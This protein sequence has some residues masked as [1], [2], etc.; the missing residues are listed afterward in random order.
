MAIGFKRFAEYF[1]AHR[2][3]QRD[4]HERD[5]A[6]QRWIFCAIVAAFWAWGYWHGDWV[7]PERVAFPVF[8]AATAVV[9]FV[10]RRYLGSHPGSGVGLQYYFLL[11]DAPLSVG[12]LVQ[13]PQTFTFLNPFLLVVVVRCGIRYGVRTMLLVWSITVCAALAL[14]PTSVYWRSELVLTL[15]FLL[16]LALVPVFF[17]SLVRKIHAVRAI[18]EE[19]ARFVAVHEAVVARS[20]FLA[21]VSHELRSPLQ[22]IVSALDVL[23]MRHGHS[24]GGNDELIARM[25]RSSLLLNTQL[26]DLL[27]LANGEAGRLEMHPS[28]FEACA[29]LEGVAA[30]AREL[31]L[32][33]GLDLVID[34]P[35]EAVFVIADGA[36]IDQVLTNLAI[37][38]I[39][40]TDVG[41]VRL[42][43]HAYDASS[44]RLR[45]A[46]ADTGPGIPEAVLPTLFA[47]DKIMTGAE[48][49]GEGSGIGLAIVRTLV[50]HL[51]GTISVTS[52]PGKGTAFK[53]EI[54]AEAVL[55]V[56]APSHAASELTGRVLI[57]DDRDDV[58]DALADVVDELG[59]ECDRASSAAI[60]ANLLATRPYDV[61]LLDIEMPVKGGAELAIETRRGTGPNRAT[62]FIGMSAAGVSDD[63]ARHFDACFT[64]PID[65]AALHQAL[66]GIAHGGARPSQPGLWLDSE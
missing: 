3:P 63:I 64:K 23:E 38:S 21:K 13:D 48:R 16:M 28:P 14:L 35:P 44:R 25:R 7:W 66:F 10:Y 40:Y 6:L 39:R 45:F 2:V 57:V 51:G 42:S 1:G 32:A 52:R 20:A 54:P 33:R 26:R 61:A 5:R 59:F 62:R 22:G 8:V 31:A 47:P 36:R 11:T 50:D 37:N 53:L 43:L 30:G 24:S 9:S 12:V 19:R 55:D 49:R 34:L 41:Q 60:G 46:V 17:P 18:E 56:A 29:L 4:E 58:L 65:Y 27:T 15:S